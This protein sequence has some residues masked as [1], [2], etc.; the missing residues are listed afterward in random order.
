M[1][2]CFKCGE[3]KELSLFYKHKKMGDGYLGK[4][5]SCTKV[6]VRSNEAD[7]DK[8]EKGVIRVIYKT[9]NSSSKKRGHEKPDYSKNQLAEWLY[10]NGFKVLYDGWVS[11][12][13]VKSKKPSVDRID[14]LKGYSIDNIRLVTWNDNFKSAVSDK[15]NGKGSQGSQ[16]KPVGKLDSNLELISAYVSYWSAVRECG[17]SIE[18][19]IKNRVK[20]RNGFYWEYI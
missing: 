17:Y 19:Q 20:C 16:C 9:Q 18:H 8:T 4:C 3:K 2:I 10:S 14:D 5:K 15:M 6:D 13:Y 12:G 7:Y 1:K 11:S